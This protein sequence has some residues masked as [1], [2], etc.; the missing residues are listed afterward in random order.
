[1]TIRELFSPPSTAD[2]AAAAYDAMSEDLNV[3]AAELL[4]VDDI[5][6]TTARVRTYAWVA[7]RAAAAEH[8]DPEPPPY[9]S[10]LCP[11]DDCL[12]Y[13]WRTES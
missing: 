6:A 13:M 5:D 9:T 4:A 3:M 1:M 10:D 8:T 11:C 12:R 2:R 7:F